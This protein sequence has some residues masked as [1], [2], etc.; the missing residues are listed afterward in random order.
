[1]EIR[2][3]VSGG[4]IRNKAILPVASIID[5]PAFMPMPLNNLSL[6]KKKRRSPA[7][8]AAWAQLEHCTRRLAETAVRP[9]I[10]GDVLLVRLK[11]REVEPSVP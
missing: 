2:P 4:I 8:G 10:L 5:V 7:D 3:E 9:D 1:M 11:L 6:I